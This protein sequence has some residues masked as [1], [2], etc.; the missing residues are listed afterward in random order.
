MAGRDGVGGTGGTAEIIP[1]VGGA[2]S[3]TDSGAGAAS[4]GASGG[5]AGTSTGGDANAAG[6]APD[7][8]KADCPQPLSG[9][10]RAFLRQE[11]DDPSTSGDHATQQPHPFLLLVNN[12]PRVSLSR[13]KVRYFFSAENSGRW[14]AGYFWASRVNGGPFDNTKGFSPGPTL[15]VKAWPPALPG[16]DHYLELGFDTDPALALQADKYVEVRSW[17]ELEQPQGQLIQSDDWSFVPTSTTSKTVDG[18]RYRE[19]Q[20]VTVYIDD[21]LVWGA[22]PCVSVAPSSD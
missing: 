5:S 11:L 7:G 16:A 9:P 12:G 18:G 13:V 20:H 2:S 10:L 21:K 22:E 8:E 15:E 1:A 4:F 6:G 3:P 14:K 19:S 17:F